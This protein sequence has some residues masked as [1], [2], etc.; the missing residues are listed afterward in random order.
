VGKKG[1]G[2]KKGGLLS[3]ERRRLKEGKKEKISPVPFGVPL[4]LE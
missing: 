3:W 1:K 4:H 2:R